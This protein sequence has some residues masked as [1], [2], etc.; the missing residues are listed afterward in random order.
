VFKAAFGNDFITDCEAGK[1]KGDAIEIHDNV[2]AGFQDVLN[3]STED[4]SGNVVITIADWVN[5]IGVTLANL[6]ANNLSSCS[7]RSG[8]HRRRSRVI[9]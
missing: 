6:N 8:S 3:H 1:K 7:W 2:F 9:G 4:G 5:S